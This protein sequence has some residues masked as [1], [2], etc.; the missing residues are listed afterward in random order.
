MR[1]AV[2]N[3]CD[4]RVDEGVSNACG[5]CGALPTEEC[6]GQDNDDGLIDEG[7]VNYCGLCGQSR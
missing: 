2:D 4:G 1:D 3:D 7:T 6:D 5:G